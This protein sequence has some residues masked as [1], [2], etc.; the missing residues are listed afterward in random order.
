MDSGDG[1]SGDP[2]VLHPWRRPIELTDD[3]I[4]LSLYPPER[5][6]FA[7]NPNATVP[8]ASFDISP[9]GRSVALV[10]AAPGLKPTLWVRPLEA[11]DA[12]ELPGTDDAYEPVWSPDGR[13]VAFAAQGK[14]KKVPAAGGPA[15]VVADG[16]PELRGASWGADDTILFGTGSARSTGF[17]QEVALPRL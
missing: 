13:W 3:P 10:A 11:V 1:A 7:G 5:T 15:Q 4:R 9:D 2:V 17:P 14:L 12:R 8:T 6:V 16:V